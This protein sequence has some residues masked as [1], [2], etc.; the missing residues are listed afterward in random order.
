[1]GYTPDEWIEMRRRRAEE[2]AEKEREAAELDL[3]KLRWHYKADP[4]VA[5][6]ETLKVVEDLVE[7]QRQAYAN[8]KAGGM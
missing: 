3:Q 5:G 2:R 1:M 8:R 7:R 4:F 6:P